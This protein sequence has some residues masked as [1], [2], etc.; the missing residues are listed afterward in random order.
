MTTIYCLTVTGLRGGRFVRFDI[1]N[2]NLEIDILPPSTTIRMPRDVNNAPAKSV[3]IN[4]TYKEEQGAVMMTFC[5]VVTEYRS[6][7][8]MRQLANVK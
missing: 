6:R 7:S 4:R 5:L 2:I 1:I 3:I 8:T